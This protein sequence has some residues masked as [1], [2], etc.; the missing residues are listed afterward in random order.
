MIPENL[1]AHFVTDSFITAYDLNFDVENDSKR[2]LTLSPSGR[3]GRANNYIIEHHQTGNYGEWWNF[4]DH[5]DSM[6]GNLTFY[7]NYV[8]TYNSGRMVPIGKLKLVTIT[9]PKEAS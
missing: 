4:T 6:K 5:Y 2:D 1:Y 3:N 8:T 7:V 9:N